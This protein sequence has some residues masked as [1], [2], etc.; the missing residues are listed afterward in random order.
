MIQE[1]CIAAYHRR[2]VFEDRGPDAFRLWI[3]GIARNKLKE[4]IRHHGGTAKRAVDREAT[5]SSRPDT[6]YLRGPHPSP[7]VVASSAEHVERARS[8][9][10]RLP[11]DYR[12]V[13]HL[14]LEKGLAL[15]EAAEHMGRSREATK[16]LY[17]R[18]LCRLRADLG[19]ASP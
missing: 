12:T 6:G 19:E 15:R 4:A 11:E 7:S 1:A 17:G 14:A 8:A 3:T 9:M 10:E 5:R 13:L 18:A 16:K 2:G